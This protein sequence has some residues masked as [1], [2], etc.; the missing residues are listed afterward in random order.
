MFPIN[1]PTDGPD[2]SLRSSLRDWSHAQEPMG[3]YDPFL[4]AIGY[5]SDY[6]TRRY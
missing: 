1:Y 5:R 2:L 6:L 3:E 4:K